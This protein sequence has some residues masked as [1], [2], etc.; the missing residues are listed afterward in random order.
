LANKYS[1]PKSLRFFPHGV[2]LAV[3]ALTS[4]P[5]LKSGI[6]TMEEGLLLISGEMVLN[7]AMGNADF[8]HLYGPGDS[9]AVAG[10]FFLLGVSLTTERLLGLFY[11]LLLMSAIYRL[12]RS[13][14]TSAALGA[15]LVGWLILIP[16]GLTAYSWVAALSF[17]ATSLATVTSAGHHKRRWF[18]AGLLAG[19]SLLFRPDFVIAIFLGFGWSV[20]KAK[21]SL[22]RP[23]IYG[24]L[25]GVSP[26]L[27]HLVTAGFRSVVEGIFIDPVFRLRDGRRLPIPPRWNDSGDFFTR[28]SDLLGGPDPW[29]S[30]GH[31]AQLTLLFWMV[32]L[33]LIVALVLSFRSHKSQLI[34][35]S[36]L[37]LG[38]VPQLLQRPTPNH[39][40][41]VGVLVF[42]ALILS[43]SASLKTKVSGLW[44]AF[45]VFGSLLLIAPHHVG[46]SVT[47]V[48]LF[49]GAQKTSVSLT[50]QG[51]T[52][53]VL[54]EAY[55]NE[56]AEIFLSLDQAAAPG[57]S[58]FIGPVDLRRTNYSETW[59]YHLLPDFVPASYH[60]EMNPGLANR[61]G[62]RLA[63]ELEQS[64]WLLLS[65]RFDGWQEPNSSVL[66]GAT[67]PAEVAA[68]QFCLYAETQTYRLL[69]NCSLS[70]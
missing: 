52:L 32:L 57:D 29:P 62:G 4:L 48:S 33:A 3:M 12:G 31:P 65:N 66:P 50:H 44:P 34:S 39:V 18:F 5:L 22:R 25:L 9:W 24:V 64:D 54:N 35:L 38:S 51:R 53:P 23:A 47:D 2:V 67:E 42:S 15:T 40:R 7:G 63:G 43:L 20:R 30:L 69:K 27:V 17:G 70:S 45:L 37:A 46:R 6:A 60:L 21:P 13:V 68:T 49:W 1:L 59:L 16:F 55:R 56:V 26:Y 61:E 41:F 11:R 36:L 28:V 14:S 58:I 8:E 10:A 19:I